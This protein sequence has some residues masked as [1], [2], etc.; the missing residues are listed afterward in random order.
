MDYKARKRKRKRIAKYYFENP[1]NNSLEEMSK[2]F[3]LAKPTISKA[4]CEALK[5]RLEKSKVRKWAKL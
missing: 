2:K 1:E 3:N 5:H 4:I